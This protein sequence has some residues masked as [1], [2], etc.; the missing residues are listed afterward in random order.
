MNQE[1]HFLLGPLLG[2]VAKRRRRLSHG[3]GDSNQGGMPQ[4]QFIKFAT[5]RI[6]G[7]AWERRH[8]ACRLYPELFLPATKGGGL[9]ALPGRPSHLGRAPGRD[10]LEDDPSHQN[11]NPEHNRNP[12]KLQSES[13]YPK[14]NSD[15]LDGYC[16]SHQAENKP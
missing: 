6:L 10:H 16:E 1:N 7:G 4:M 5:N 11:N 2:G 13:N 14:K 9:G 8:L 15:Q 12:N 3:Q